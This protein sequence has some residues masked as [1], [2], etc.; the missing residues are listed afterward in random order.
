MRSEWGVEKMEI[1]SKIYFFKKFG[2]EGKRYFKV[3]VRLICLFILRRKK[4]EYI[5]RLGKGLMEKV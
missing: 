3:E 2:Y 5:Y 4:F 1:V